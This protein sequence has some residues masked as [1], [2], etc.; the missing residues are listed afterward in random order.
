M[1]S[2]RSAKAPFVRRR[3]NNQI[4]FEHLAERS[5][6]AM[7]SSVRRTD[8]ALPIGLWIIL[9]SCSRFMTD[10]RTLSMPDRRGR[11]S[12]RAAPKRRRRPCLHLFP[13]ASL[14]I[15]GHPSSTL[16]L[17]N[18][19]MHPPQLFSSTYYL[20][21]DASR[22][23]RGAEQDRRGRRDSDRRIPADGSQTASGRGGRL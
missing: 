12:N 22:L 19:R 1:R 13:W 10:S 8:L 16:L 2:F 23:R 15:N 4:V 18:D 17:P 9:L 20:R 5:D 7:P 3:S 21:F 6:S 14:V 11:A